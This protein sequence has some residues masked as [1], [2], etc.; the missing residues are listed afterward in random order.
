M[1][2]HLNPFCYQELTL[3]NPVYKSEISKPTVGF[4]LN[5]CSLCLSR[6]EDYKQLDFA[7]S[8]LT[9]FLES[10]IRGTKR[11]QILDAH[12]APTEPAV[13]P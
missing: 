11:S 7:K 4:G 5:V 12:K 8:V 13:L 2:F 1:R 3:D 10:Y 9:H 6:F